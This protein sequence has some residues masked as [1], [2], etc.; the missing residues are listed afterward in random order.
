[1]ISY[2]AYQIYE[3]YKRAYHCAN[4]AVDALKRNYADESTIKKAERAAAINEA[5]ANLWG[6][7][8]KYGQTDQGGNLYDPY[9]E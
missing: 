2:T 3:E 6:R 4:D 5:L 8:Y 1:M 9:G 7:I